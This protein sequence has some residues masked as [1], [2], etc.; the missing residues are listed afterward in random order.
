MQLQD[1]QNRQKFILTSE[2]RML[3]K[4]KR[5][6]LSDV[7][8]MDSSKKEEYKQFT[9]EIRQLTLRRAELTEQ[10]ERLREGMSTLTE[11]YTKAKEGMESYAKVRQVDIEAEAQ[12]IIKNAK[13]IETEALSKHTEADKLVTDY[14]E[15]KKH[16]TFEEEMLTIHRNEHQTNVVTLTTQRESFQKEKEGWELRLQGFEDTRSQ[17]EK[18]I[19]ALESRK[20]EIMKQLT[21]DQEIIASNLHLAEEK[22][23][24]ADHNLISIRQREEVLTKREGELADSQRLLKDQRETLNRAVAEFRQKGVQI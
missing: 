2:I 5:E 21:K 3:E 16:L 4:Q 6:L 15:R 11:A 12:Q 9:T 8:R 23:K 13:I 20:D 22:N 17:L 10:I 7:E 18:E 24:Q 14:T 19:T 1:Q